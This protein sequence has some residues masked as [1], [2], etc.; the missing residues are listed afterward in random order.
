V[1]LV[2]EP[3]RD[4]KR[5]GN[6]HAK[7]EPKAGERSVTGQA[8]SWRRKLV[9]IRWES[10]LC[11]ITGYARDELLARGLHDISHPD[12]MP[13]GWA[14]ARRLLAGEIDSYRPQTLRAPGRRD[15]LGGR[16]G[17]A[18]PRAR[19]LSQL[20]HSSDRGHQRTQRRRGQVCRASACT[21]PQVFAERFGQHLA[22]LAASIEESGFDPT[23]EE[24]ATGCELF[25]A[26]GRAHLTAPPQSPRSGSWSWKA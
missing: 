8:G 17:I 5:Q 11:R 16:H 21:A 19:W 10:T 15:R 18:R 13:E 22:G 6:C 26:L 7:A 12:D 25:S 23:I 14:I 4:A 3:P 24:L 2:L 1:I 9:H 20:L